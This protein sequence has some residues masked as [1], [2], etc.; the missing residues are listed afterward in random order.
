[1]NVIETPPGHNP[2]LQLTEYD[3]HDILAS[4][5]MNLF[6]AGNMSD[7]ERLVMSDTCGCFERITV[8]PEHPK[9]F[10]PELVEKW[11]RY[12]NELKDLLHKYD[13]EVHDD[14]EYTC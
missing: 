11:E 3:L 2:I 10:P 5:H 6:G 4:A 12:M 7:D 14:A 9:D 1:M 8:K 13:A